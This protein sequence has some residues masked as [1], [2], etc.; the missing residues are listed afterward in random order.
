MQHKTVLVGIAGGTGSGK[1]TVARK[2]IKAFKNEEAVLLEQDCYYKDLAHLPYEVSRKTNFDHPDSLDF[3]L[4][5]EHLNLLNSHSPIQKPLYDFTT[6]S[7]LKDSETIQPSRIIIVEGI[8]IFALESLREMF[9]VKIFVD[10]DADERL[11]RR[12]ER[13][14]KERGRSFESIKTQYLNTVKPSFLEFAEPTKRYADIIIPRG[15][16]NHIAINMVIAKLKSILKNEEQ[17][18]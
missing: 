4:L 13:D 5:I 14:I 17:H 3:D 8:L 1:T 16:E 11:L 15:G 2:I 10:T 9:D 7:R 12:I 18:T 6:N